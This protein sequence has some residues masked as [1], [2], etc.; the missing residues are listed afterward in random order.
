MHAVVK[1]VINLS[2]TIIFESFWWEKNP[3]LRILA[4]DFENA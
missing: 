1:Q 2:M 3:K 4:Y